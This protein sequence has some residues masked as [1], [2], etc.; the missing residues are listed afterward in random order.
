MAAS[1]PTIAVYFNTGQSPND[2]FT[3]EDAT[4]GLLDTGGVLGG[5]ILYPAEPT[6]VTDRAYELD[7]TRG[8]A[9]EFDDITTGVCK[10]SFRNYDYAFDPFGTKYITDADGVR[11][12]DADGN[13]LT[14]PATDSSF[15]GYIEPGHR[16]TVEF[17]GMTVFDGFTEDWDLQW[18]A[19]G[20]TNAEL[21]AEDALGTL[22]R[23]RFTEWTTTAAQTAGERLASA[24]DR[25]EVN[26]AATREFDTGVSTL[27]AD[28]VTWGSN[29]LN[30]CQLVAQ[31]DLG[32]LFVSRQGVLTFRDRLSIAGSASKLTFTDDGSTAF[33]IA[34]IGIT[35]GN[36]LLYTRASIDREGGTAQTVVADDLYTSQYGIRS[37][38]VSGLLL[39]SDAQS[40]DM[41]EYLV[42]IYAE[43]LA[44]ITSLAVHVSA[45]TD[46]ADQALVASLDIGD[47]VTVVWTPPAASAAIE[48]VVVVDGI[49]HSYRY[50]G[51]HTMVFAFSQAT[52]RQVFTIEDDTLG[53]LD[54]GGVLAF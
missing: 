34:A 26:F 14:A 9:S 18:D 44:R 33:P 48:Q 31:S 51:I 7:I 22:A 23:K 46:P 12:T 29:V 21:E 43:P 2:L 32:R 41:A 13:P 24:L 20:A 47:V 42:G 5:D 25:S 40:L 19:D 45:L 35:N 39:D 16:V 27:Q 54:T 11:I 50:G 36:E 15:S 49:R 38:S 8:R 1:D 6:Y 17:Y 52:Q 28:L 37:L 4:L 53:A 30:Y 10:V 3:I